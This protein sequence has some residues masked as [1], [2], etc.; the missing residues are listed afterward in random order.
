MTVK[1][2]RRPSAERRRSRESRAAGDAPGP[3]S[4]GRVLDTLGPAVVPLVV[5]RGLEVEVG[6][7]MIYDVLE[8]SPIE[9]GATVLGVGVRPDGA[10]ARRVIDDASAADATVVV[11]KLRDRD[12]TVVAEAEAAG[13]ALLAIPDEMSW[14]HLNALLTR[15]LRT[16]GEPVSIGGMASVSLGDLFALAN[17][18]AAMAGGAV[19]IE[20]YQGRVLAYSNLEGQEIDDAR[21]RSILGRQVPM[22]P[23]VREAYRKLWSS[24][25][26]VRIDDVGDF[27][28][29]PRLAT[30][31]RVAGETLG[32]I[33]VVEGDRPLADDAAAS[34][35]DAARVAA[36]H[37]I[38]ARG[39][40]E[41]DRRV[42][43]DLLRS[44]L[45]GRGTVDAAAARLGIDPRSGLEVLG[46]HLPAG[47]HAE[48][49]LRRERLVDA[50]A[51]Y[52]EAFRRRAACVSVGRTVYAV[53]PAA[54][55]RRKEGVG[56]LARDIL[57]HAESSLRTSLHAAIG[58]TVKRLRDLP[59]ARVEVDRILQVLTSAGGDR[60]LAS[61]TD[62]RKEAIILELMEIAAEHPELLRGR[63]EDIAAH[64]AKH[65]TTYVETLRQYLDAFG[66]IPTAAQKLGVH[67][68][69]FRYRL[70]RLQELFELDLDDPDERLILWL[71]LRLLPPE[72]VAAADSGEDGA[73]P[74]SSP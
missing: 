50:V 41:I 35:L 17:A 64:D 10:E 51:L 65:R 62:V 33:W 39:S 18:I 4:L 12:C 28:I 26:V 60:K 13:L 61:I 68:N 54:R 55:D 44:M 32:S 30:A 52:C 19:T 46:F 43:G 57:E 29:R 72:P 5:P 9:R 7:P 1:P 22:T 48:E 31:V 16:P 34:L 36:L 11:F 45:E 73:A 59:A 25:G 27:E 70:R 6:E 58:P 47:E 20:D 14:N 53:V 69:T 63:L 56:K 2:K 67:Q 38:H 74:D 8:R 40:R 37:M 71:Q 23:G 24:D 15:I 21:Q 66:F 3:I 42:R 49:E